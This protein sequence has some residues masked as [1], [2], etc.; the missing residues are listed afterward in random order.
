MYHNDKPKVAKQELAVLR[1]STPFD[2][3]YWNIRDPPP[4]ADDWE[5]KKWRRLYQYDIV[6]R[7]SHCMLLDYPTHR[8]AGPAP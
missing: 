5:A 6:S 3:V 4:E 8:T 7:L 1:R 2:L